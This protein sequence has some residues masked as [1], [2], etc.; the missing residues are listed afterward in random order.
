ML[1]IGM[2][3]EFHHHLPD[4]RRVENR[5]YPDGCLPAL[6]RMHG[7][8]HGAMSRAGRL[9]RVLFLRNSSLPADAAIGR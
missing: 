4:K 7:L 3:A 2:V 8:R 5:D 1:E 6:P 9:P